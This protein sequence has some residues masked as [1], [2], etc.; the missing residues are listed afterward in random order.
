MATPENFVLLNRESLKYHSSINFLTN[1]YAKLA[2]LGEFKNDLISREIVKVERQKNETMIFQINS[3]SFKLRI[4]LI[5]PA[6]LV[7]D[8]SIRYDSYRMR[9][10]FRN[11][12]FHIDLQ[13]SYTC[14]LKKL[15]L[16]NFYRLENPM[17]LVGMGHL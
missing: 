14:L 7:V 3:Q 12:K 1:R 15:V 11:L 2:N 9:K 5:E 10:Y 4:R 16:F 6:P 13:A 17:W 8:G